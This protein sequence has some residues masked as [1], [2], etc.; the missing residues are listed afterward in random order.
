MGLVGHNIIWW[1]NRSFVREKWGGA[2]IQN[3]E[4]VQNLFRP[5]IWIP[6][7]EPKKMAY[8]RYELT[9]HLI[10]SISGIKVCFYFYLCPFPKER[11]FRSLSVFFVCW[12]CHF[13]ISPLFPIRVLPALALF[14]EAASPPTKLTRLYFDSPQF[15]KLTRHEC[16]LMH[17]GAVLSF[18]FFDPSCTA[19]FLLSHLSFPLTRP[20]QYIHPAPALLKIFWTVSALRSREGFTWSFALL[21]LL[22]FSPFTFSQL[23]ICSVI[24]TLHPARSSSSW[25]LFGAFQELPPALSSWIGLPQEAFQELSP[26][27]ESSCWVSSGSQVGRAA[28]T[29]QWRKA[30]QMQP[31]SVCNALCVHFKHLNIRKTSWKHP[32]EKSYSRALRWFSSGSQVGRAV[33]DSLWTIRRNFL[34]VFRF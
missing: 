2:K 8:F 9:P 7:Y 17:E 11:F 29:Q 26:A 24:K 4:R 16:Y 20:T 28:A 19:F 3:I 5:K 1:E 12:K 30:K 25:D 32:V 14:A 21:L 6:C 23:Q 10:H 33:A 27:C 15:S 22:N 13:R 34:F 18:P 31:M